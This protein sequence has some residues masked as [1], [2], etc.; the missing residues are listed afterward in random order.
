MVRKRQIFQSI[1]IEYIGNPTLSVSVDGTE[2]YSKQLPSNSVR[3]TRRVLLPDTAIG[4]VA[5]IQTTGSSVMRHSFQSTPDSQFSQQQI[6]Q[7]FEVTFTGSVKLKLTL[8]GIDKNVNETATSVT[9]AQ[10]KTRTQDTRRVYYPPLSYGYIPHLE[11]EDITTISGEVVQ[12][13][14]IALPL[15]FSRGLRYH[16]EVQ[17]T[18]Q[19][20]VFVNL[21][22][23]GNKID[24]AYFFESPDN[25]DQFITEKKLL[26]KDVRGHVF[27]WVQT[28]G[29]G[30][31]AVFE[32]DTT[33]LDQ[34]PPAQEV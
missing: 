24:E 31:V 3:K 32:T 11:Q 34:D 7:G 22:V 33:L 6:F 16:S 8:D 21:Y 17:V 15:R 4:Y 26:T 14:P 25:P 30:E 12:F 19:G 13:R 2:V 18:Y 28:K 1:F 5:D 23:D 10:R 20:E 27:Q 9:L 29:D